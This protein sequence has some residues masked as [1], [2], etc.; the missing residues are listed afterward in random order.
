MAKNS[1]SFDLLM[2]LFFLTLTMVSKCG[3]V[4]VESSTSV[5][6]NQNVS[7]DPSLEDLMGAL[8]HE[9]EKIISEIGEEETGEILIGLDDFVKQAYWYV[10]TNLQPISFDNVYDFNFVDEHTTTR[11]PINHLGWTESEIEAES[12]KLTSFIEDM[13]LHFRRPDKNPECFNGLTDSQ[14]NEWKQD[15]S[16]AFKSITEHLELVHEQSKARRSA[17]NRIKEAWERFYREGLY[18]RLFSK[19]LNLLIS[20]VNML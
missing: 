20:K 9:T 1:L 13:L 2:S 4:P 6:M 5:A 19:T 17:R 14:V 11:I 18:G 15:Y 12:L 16:L 8:Y 3:G 7:S 10:K